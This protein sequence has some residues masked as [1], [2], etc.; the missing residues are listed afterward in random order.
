[1]M[2]WCS[3]GTKI[4]DEA[5]MLDQSS[6]MLVGWGQLCTFSILCGSTATASLVTP[7]PWKDTPCLNNRHFILPGLNCSPEVLNRYR[8]VCNLYECPLEVDLKITILLRLDKHISWCSPTST[9]SITSWK[10]LGTLHNPNGMAQNLY[11]LWGTMNAVF[12][13]TTGCTSNCQ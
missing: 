13:L 1:M 4:L 5:M 7:C 2:K 8:T 11:K 12:S 6:V 9:S 10:V 3:N